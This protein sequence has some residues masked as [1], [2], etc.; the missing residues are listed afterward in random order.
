MER[1]LILDSNSIINR[2]FYGIRALSAPDGTPTNAVYG[3]LNILMK[4]INDYKPQYILATFDLK[5]PTF[6]H[7]MYD[8][9][10]ATRHR[11][12]DELAAQMPVMKG[13]LSDMNIPLLELEGYEADDIIGTVSRVCGEKGIECYIA[14]GD[15]DDLQ[16]ADNGTTVVLASTKMGQSVTDLYDEAA[17]KAKYGVT[18]SEFVD[19]KALMGDTSD[20]IPGVAGI[21]EKTAS[22]LIA[23]FSTIENMYEHIDEANVS[24]KIKEKLLADKDNAYLSKQ[25]AK[26]NVNVP[27]EIDF[28]SG[29]YSCEAPDYKPEL[30][31]N[32]N[33]LGLKS[34]IKKMNLTPPE[35][36]SADADFFNGK[37]VAYFTNGGE[38]TAAAAA[39][40]STIALY[41]ELRNGIIVSAAAANAEK[42]FCS[43]PELTGDALIEALAPILSDK[44]I[45]KYVCA[46]KDV[47]IALD[48]KAELNGCAFDCAIAAYLCDPSKALD[49]D[50]LAAQYLGVYVDSGEN[51]QLSLFDDEK[52]SDVPGRYALIIYALQKKLERLIEDNG[53]HMLFYEVEMPLIKVLAS[54][55]LLGITLDT[56]ALKDFGDMLSVKIADLE[57]R[58]YDASGESFNINSPKQL[59][60]IL[61]EKLGLPHGKKT[62]SGWSTKADILEKLSDVPV[63][64]DVLEYRTYQKLKST[65]CD[66]LVKLADPK[67]G[68]IHSAFHQTGTVTGRLSS[69]EP[70]MQNI[71]TRTALGREI[72]KM[73]AAK[74]GCVLVD[75]DYS[76]IELR[77]LA[78]LSQDEN[79]INAFKRGM[80]I[81]AVTASQIL[82]I[83]IEQLT[84]E[85]RSS[86]KAINFG[87]IY[88]MGEYSLSQ[89][90]GITFK[91]AKKYM[92]D[93]FT[94]YRGV[95]EFMEKTKKNAHDT[96]YVKTMMNRVRYIPEL[97]S[98]NVNLRSF[99]ERAAMN[100]PVQGSAADIIKLAMVRVYNR[101]EAEGLKAR[102]ILQVHDE[103]IIETPLDEVETVKE[104]LAYE[105]ENTVKLDVP[106]IAEA[107]SGKSWYD[108]K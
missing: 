94:K 91:Q 9:Y 4:L 23:Q 48:G 108:A 77:I 78:H 62:K 92:D 17:V 22:K 14:T 89:D 43:A 16:L 35:G 20:N 90:L 10:K 13:I 44:G 50:S 58:I 5:A 52:P 55:Q 26:I 75:A 12:P 86:A 3:F 103:L 60:V 6:R 95:Y 38:L 65:Y 83:P 7:K 54:M 30:Y 101:L 81:H 82:G 74:E 98:S 85:Q 34:V 84:K 80:D 49:I 100:T 56:K 64:A 21:G 67:T 79:M 40:G 51:A 27:I 69:S 46:V 1:L 63:V 88:G 99:G 76:Q 29:T 37:T 97:N 107:G 11:M 105:M 47:L 57:K 72:R 93:Y 96:G 104:L 39:L 71:P 2:A 42:A 106:L 66:S 31:T 45:I 102:L 8:G 59:G 70:N 19:M 61:F 41:F 53:Q 25:L 73:F 32:L 18:P 24:A 28:S 87:I 68:R 36:A 15:R 33:R